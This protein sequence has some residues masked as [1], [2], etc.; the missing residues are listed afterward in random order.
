VDP[1]RFGVKFLNFPKSEDAAASHRRVMDTLVSRGLRAELK[2]GNL[3]SGSLLVAINFFPDEPPATLD[4]S[5][6][7]VQLPTMSGKVEAIEDSVTS[8]LRNLNKTAIGVQGTLTNA[9][10][11]LQNLDK[12]LGT[13]RGTLTNADTLMGNVNQLIEPNSVLDTELN[14]LLQ[15]GGDAARALRV[16]ADYL[17]RHPE[18]LIHGKSGEAK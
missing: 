4:W 10:G 5:R 1:M 11:L 7:P 13:T 18:A 8:L 17:E 16:L 15:Q 2:T 3:I 6:D 12:T 9:D 14:I